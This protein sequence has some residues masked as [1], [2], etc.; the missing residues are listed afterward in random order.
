[1]TAALYSVIVMISGLAVAPT[2]VALLTDWVFQDETR[3]G[4]SLQWVCGVAGAA[5]ALLLM[6]TLRPYAHMRTS[7]TATR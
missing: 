6:R 3:V 1:M 7:A 2:L 4:D 5:G